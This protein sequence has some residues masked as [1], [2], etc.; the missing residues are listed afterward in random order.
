MNSRGKE[1][2]DFLYY[3]DNSKS[4]EV[5]SQEPGTKAK[6]IFYYVEVLGHFLKTAQGALILC[7]W[8]ESPGVLTLQFMP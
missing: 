6:Q 2:I 1:R 7:P 3:L 5:T 4:L 8:L